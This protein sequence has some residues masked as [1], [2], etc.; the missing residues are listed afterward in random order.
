MKVG[1]TKT[2]AYVQAPLF[3]VSRF[4]AWFVLAARTT[5]CRRLA[6]R[7]LDTHAP[8]FHVGVVLAL[9][10]RTASEAK[11]ESLFQQHL[12]FSLEPKI[13]CSRSQEFLYPAAQKT[14]EDGD[15]FFPFF[16]RWGDMTPIQQTEVTRSQREERRQVLCPYSRRCYGNIWRAC[17]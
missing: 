3:K 9:K 5:A 15:A 7:W 13:P 14:L 17:L 2:M 11:A 10:R 8:L 4:H 16:L 1:T 6:F 12:P